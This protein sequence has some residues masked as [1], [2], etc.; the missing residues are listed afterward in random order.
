MREPIESFGSALLS[1]SEFSERIRDFS[2]QCLPG[3]GSPIDCQSVYLTRRRRRPLCFGVNGKAKSILSEPVAG[4]LTD[5]VPARRSLV[6]MQA[7]LAD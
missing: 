2:N 3:D 1:P 4:E 5:F 6:L 7:S